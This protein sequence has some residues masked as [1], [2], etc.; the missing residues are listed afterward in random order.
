MKQTILLTISVLLLVFSSCKK[1]NPTPSTPTGNATFWNNNS[2]VGVITVYVIGATYT[3]Q[4]TYNYTPTGCNYNGCA[5]FTLPPG[6]YMWSAS[7]TTGQSWS[8]NATIPN[9]VL[10]VTEGGCLLFQL[11]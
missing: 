10:T 6:N 7:S 4:I 9:N 3:S 8:S 1:D 11:Q 2:N 5:N